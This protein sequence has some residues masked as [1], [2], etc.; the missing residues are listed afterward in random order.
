MKCLS[1]QKEVN[2]GDRFCQYCG[3]PVQ[4]AS[5]APTPQPVASQPVAPQP[6]PMVQQQATPIA[7]PVAQQPQFQTNPAT[8]AQPGKKK[9]IGASIFVMLFSIIGSILAFTALNMPTESKFASS[10]SIHSAC[11]A[12]IW[13]FWSAVV[14]VAIAWLIIIVTRAKKNRVL[15]VSTVFAVIAVLLVLVPAIFYSKV[16]KKYKLTD[17][18]RKL[19]EEDLEDIEDLFG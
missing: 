8:A 1:C 5:P 7:Q 15:V 12:Y 19:T 2:T 9:K 18:D 16:S 14:C 11:E 4:V 13:L 3:T 17:P 6:V 10:A